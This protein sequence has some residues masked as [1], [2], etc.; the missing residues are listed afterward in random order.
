MEDQ[1]INNIELEI[2]RK[3]A[4]NRR[5]RLIEIYI[6][7]IFGILLSGRALFEIIMYPGIGIGIVQDRYFEILLSIMVIVFPILYRLIFNMLPF[8]SIRRINEE[9]YNH[10]SEKNRKFSEYK[11]VDSLM[12]KK[13][14]TETAE[15]FLSN[16]TVNSKKLAQ[17]LYSR[18]GVYLLIGVFIAFSG[19]AFFYLQST[20]VNKQQEAMS[21]LLTL[22]PNF[23]ILFF[24]EFIALFFLKQYKS[25]MDEFR[26][27]EAL[28]RSREET[29]A[30]VKLIKESG[31]PLNIYNLIEKCGFRSSS[32][33]LENGQT[34]DLL[35]S[36]KLNKDEMEIFGKI[37]DIV[38]K[39]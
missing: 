18:S 3:N 6:W 31:E 23:G 16:L 2:L 27:Y 24:I 37:L 38:G 29:L 5:K 22:A 1:G 20:R 15:E 33:K 13:T 25:A 26:Y 9:A 28:Q 17:G 30:L 14:S 19:L 7:L 35:E 36:K 4:K 11:N 34:T 21:L 8:E 39:K 32:E 12:S 10:S